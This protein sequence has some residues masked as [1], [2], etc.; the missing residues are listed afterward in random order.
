VLKAAT[1]VYELLGTEGLEV[2]N[3]PEPDAP[4]IDSRLGYWIRGGKHAM[5][6]ADWK[7]YMDFAD[8]WLK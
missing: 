5:T 1:P 3:M 8:Q 2:A 6:P 7:V 4:L